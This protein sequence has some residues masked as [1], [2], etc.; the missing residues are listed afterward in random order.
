MSLDINPYCSYLQVPLSQQ[1]SMCLCKWAAGASPYGLPLVIASAESV[2]I[3]GMCASADTPI[4]VFIGG[5]I[6]L[7]SLIIGGL[8]ASLLAIWLFAGIPVGIWFRFAGRQNRFLQ[9]DHFAIESVAAYMMF[10]IIDVLESLMCP[11]A[12]ELKT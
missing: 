10:F 9:Q 11:G 4:F 7:G 12:A 3:G 1:R 8:G 2:V 5:C 6:A